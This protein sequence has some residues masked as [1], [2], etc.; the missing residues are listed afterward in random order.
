LRRSRSIRVA[1]PPGEAIRLFTP[2]GER[3]WVE[4]WDPQFPAGESGDGSEPGKVFTTEAHG[5][6]TV[7]VA[8]DR[9]ADRVRYAR[10]TPGV[11]AG[12]VEVRLGA[13][14]DGG[15]TAEVT[16]DLTALSDEGE[17]EL[18]EFEASY[19]AE[20]GEWER[21]IAQAGGGSAAG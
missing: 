19:D 12:T 9:E 21:L 6:F 8:V 4:G 16:Y 10:V 15:T 7:W 14:D 2:V 13:A 20:I 17:R 11:W 1:L 3:D 5:P 18:R